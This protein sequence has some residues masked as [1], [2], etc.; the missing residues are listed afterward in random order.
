[1]LTLIEA[2]STQSRPAAIHSADE[3]GMNT[4]AIEARI[5]PTRK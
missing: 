3:Y 2:S 4:R 1:M 5:A